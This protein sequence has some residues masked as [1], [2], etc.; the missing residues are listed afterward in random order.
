MGKKKKP[1]SRK[2]KVKENLEIAAL[3]AMILEAV[4]DLID[5]LNG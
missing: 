4:L 5:L 1:A 2:A 3:I